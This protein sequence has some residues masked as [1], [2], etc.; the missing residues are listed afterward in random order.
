MIWKYLIPRE[1]N[2]TKTK[3]NEIHTNTGYDTVYTQTHTTT[4]IIYKAADTKQW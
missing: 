2:K 1:N 3:Q 4:L